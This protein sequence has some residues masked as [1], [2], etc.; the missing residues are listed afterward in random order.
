MPTENKDQGL[1]YGYIEG[2]VLSKQLL[3][4]C[5]PSSREIVVEQ[6]EGPVDTPWT[7]TSLATH[8]QRKTYQDITQDIPTDMQWEQAAN[9]PTGGRR[10]YGKQVL[11]VPAF[12]LPHHDQSPRVLMPAW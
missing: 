3:N 9:H 7:I 1:V 12:S 10:V 6:L 8:P 11:T 2:V 5:E 4:S